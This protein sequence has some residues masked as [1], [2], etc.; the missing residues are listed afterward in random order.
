[1]SQTTAPSPDL[2]AGLYERHLQRKGRR[3]QTAISLGAARA[4]WRLLDGRA[5]GAVLELGSGFSSSVIRAWQ[6]AHPG[7]VVYTTDSEWKWLGVTLY[8]LELEELDTSHMLH[9]DVFARLP[10]TQER[11]D[12]I[13]FDLADT[14]TRAQWAPRVVEWLRPAGLL[15][16]DDWHMPHYRARVL[17]L[18]QERGFTVTPL[19]ETTDEFGRYLATAT[20]GG[21]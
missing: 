2:L 16:L 13:F 1:M 11:F 19:P 18:L 15:V 4:L 17:P 12:L 21:S 10:G 5:P 3:S 9:H 6:R 14:D 7:A 20:R 8:E